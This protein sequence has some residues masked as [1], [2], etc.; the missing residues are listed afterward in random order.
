MIFFFFG[1]C[2]D[3]KAKKLKQIVCNSLQVPMGEM[4]LLE[5]HRH[6]KTLQYYGVAT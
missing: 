5:K 1:I 2:L 6:C 4:G 3:L